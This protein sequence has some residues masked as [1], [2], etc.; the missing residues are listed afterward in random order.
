MGLDCQY[1]E[2]TRPSSALLP[3]RETNASLEHRLR[4]M[5]STVRLLVG[6]QLN[7]QSTS[8]AALPNTST[9]PSGAVHITEPGHV[10]IG[11][12][13]QQP[14]G[15]AK[16]RDSVDGMASITFADETFSGAFG[17]GVPLPMCT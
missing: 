7:S 12:Q 14:S 11:S 13:V 6:S 10:T 2:F 1:G 16:P 15:L 4:D 17:E 5:E 8:V 3:E 9:L